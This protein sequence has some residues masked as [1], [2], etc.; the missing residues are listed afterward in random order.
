MNPALAAAGHALKQHQRVKKKKERGISRALVSKCLDGIAGIP[1]NA[2]HAVQ[3]I[4]SV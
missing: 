1:S 3:P 4:G 2:G